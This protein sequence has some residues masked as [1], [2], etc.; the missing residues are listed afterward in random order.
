M[1]L[2]TRTFYRLEESIQLTAVT[3][4]WITTRPRDRL[5]RRAHR[6]YPRGRPAARPQSTPV[7]RLRGSGS[8]AIGPQPRYSLLARVSALGSA[9]SSLSLNGHLALRDPG[10]LGHSPLLWTYH[11]RPL[12]PQ[13][14]AQLAAHGYSSD[15]CV[16]CKDAAGHL[17]LAFDLGLGTYILELRSK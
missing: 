17:Y 16:A 4:M 14:S 7:A 11:S 12:P 1:I 9:W 10:C 6:D 5:K 13:L 2:C 3:W 15:S 8:A